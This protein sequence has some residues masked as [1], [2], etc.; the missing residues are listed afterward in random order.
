MDYSFGCDT[1]LQASLTTLLYSSWYLLY[2]ILSNFIFT[3]HSHSCLPFF[4]LELISFFIYW[5]TGYGNPINI[6][7]H[8]L[9][10]STEAI[11]SGIHG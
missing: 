4:L 7:D 9:L 5:L 6:I 8:T 2:V 3:R 1:T 10:L 11:R